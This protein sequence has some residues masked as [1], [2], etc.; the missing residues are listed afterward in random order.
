MVEDQIGKL[1]I[2]DGSDEHSVLIREA[3]LVRPPPRPGLPAGEEVPA[4]LR[5]RDRVQTGRQSRAGIRRPG[6]IATA[7]ARAAVSR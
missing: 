5:Q 3:G 2:L 7:N 1:S 6:R 4:F